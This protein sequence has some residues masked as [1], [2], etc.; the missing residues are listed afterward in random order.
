MKGA[1]RA[2]EKYQPLWGSWKVEELISQGNGFE[3][4]RVYK[5]ELGKRYVSA[6]KYL[7]FSIGNSDIREAQYI[8]IDKAS[9]P[10]YFKSLAGNILN[11]IELMYRLRGYSNIVIFEDHAIYEK[12]GNLGW[13]IL[14]RM[15]YLKSLPDFLNG[16]E[17]GR[18]EVAKL[19][20]DICK[21]L[22]A[23][24]KEGIIHR[25]IRDTS[26]FVSS[27]GEFKLGS[28]NMAKELSKGGRTALPLANPLYMAPELYK[29]QSYD[30][31]VDIY[32]LG[33]VMYKLLNRGRLPFLPLPPESIT[34]EDTKRSVERR[35]AGEEPEPPVDAGENLGAIILKACGYDKKD[36]Y[37][38]PY[39]FRKKLERFLKA[40][41]KALKNDSTA[42]NGIFAYE[43][44]CCEDDTAE[45]AEKQAEI[46]EICSEE[47]ERTAVAEIALSAENRGRS[48]GDNKKRLAVAAFGAAMMI[49]GF[50]IAFLLNYNPVPVEEKPASETAAKT[51]TTTPSPAVEQVLAPEPAAE[52]TGEE[53]YE[54]G[55]EH[56]KNGLY[57]SALAAFEEAKRLGYE[58]EKTDIQINA[59]KKKMEMQK[60]HKRAM[61]YYNNQDYENA[62]NAFSKLAKADASYSRSA[63]YADSFLQLAA[64]HN[65]IG[66]Q[67]YNEGK[68]EQAVEQFDKAINVLDA[69]KA[70]VKN[71]DQALYSKQMNLYKENKNKTMEKISDIEEYFKLAKECNS[72]GV[73][74]YNEGDYKKAKQEFENAIKYMSEIRKLV[75]NYSSN[76]YDGLMQIYEGNLNRAER[77]FEK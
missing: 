45:K 30:F 76:G 26:I 5:E 1:E 29:E 77:A 74:L 43:T 53:Y 25:D 67:K 24:G 75:P 10:E 73:K 34:V 39:E 60:L 11:E 37:K 21:A 27:R 64:G 20:I 49:L 14:I 63:Q 32:S 46:Q 15:E 69:M 56:M 47:Q 71:Y 36:R 61:E 35:M 9:L 65:R 41:E 68:L 4:Y 16:R 54:E 33:I 42:V 40:E 72:A 50:T 58:S 3:V 55:M 23:C 51:E 57:N 59:A 6:V 7:S 31:S 48:T 44:A 18:L 2:I 19:G 52:K 8:G 13:D 66:V 17:L 38:S 70:A 28:F 12:K 22:E 62:V